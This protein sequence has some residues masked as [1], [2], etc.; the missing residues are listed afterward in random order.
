LK[1]YQSVLVNEQSCG[2]D[3]AMNGNVGIVLL[4]TF[5]PP[6]YCICLQCHLQLETV[7]HFKNSIFARMLVT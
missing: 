5:Y 2:P 7:T 1:N 6:K 3:I 4:Y